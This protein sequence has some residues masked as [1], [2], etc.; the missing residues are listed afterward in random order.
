MPLP[1]GVPLGLWLGE[2]LLLKGVGVSVE[3]TVPSAEA[4][5]EPL[6]LAVGD[7]ELLGLPEALLTAASVP[8]GLP[9]GL[10][11]PVG[12]AEALT[13]EAA[14]LLLLGL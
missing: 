9:E 6:Q 13:V 2:T 3:L 5:R 14:L 8:T 11:L 12:D 4:E 7:C 1:V 10:A